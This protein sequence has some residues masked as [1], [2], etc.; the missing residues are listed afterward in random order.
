MSTVMCTDQIVVDRDT[1]SNLIRDIGEECA[2]E[3]IHISLEEIEEI[4][5]QFSIAHSASDADEMKNLSHKVKG[6]SS[7]IGAIQLMKLAQRNE[8]LCAEGDISLIEKDEL[9]SAYE[10]SKSVFSDI[11]AK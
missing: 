1:V 11:L 7:S 10:S 3:I 6:C 9:L 2:T 4:C 8:S 5:N